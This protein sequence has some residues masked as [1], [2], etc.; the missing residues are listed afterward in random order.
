MNYNI[1]QTGSSGNCVIINDCIAVDI[2][3]PWKKLQPHS[4]QIKLVLLTHIHGDHFKP[5]TVR[6]LHRERPAVRWACCE[7][8]V[9]PLVEAGVSKRVI[10]VVDC[11]AIARALY[12]DIYTS[13]RA[14]KIP[15][16]VPN[17]AWDIRIYGG[18]SILYATDLATLDG[19]E[20]KNYTMYFLEA[21]HDRAEIEARIAAKHAAG[22][23]AYEEA[24]ARN[25]LSREQAEDWLARNAGP[26][27][28]YILLHQHID[29][30]V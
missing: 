13:I 27:S 18:E 8:M 10:D 9:Q 23:F 16:N 25:H 28:K 19:I 12:P 5:A 1:L 3:I 6:A 11:Q 24:A 15:H 22:E 4:A 17:C 2:G 14:Q 29:K 30:G 20:A 7:W 21:N 26:N